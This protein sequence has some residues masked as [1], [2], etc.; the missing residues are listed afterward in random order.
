M[1]DVRKTTWDVEKIMSDVENH[2]ATPQRF[3]NTA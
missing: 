3:H 2:F 1:S